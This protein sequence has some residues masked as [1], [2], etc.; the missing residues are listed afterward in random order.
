MENNLQSPNAEIRL[1]KAEEFLSR[2][3]DLSHVEVPFI[4]RCSRSYIKFQLQIFILTEEQRK[5][6]KTHLRFASMDNA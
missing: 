3:F 6:K 4:L 5:P 1:K 2:E